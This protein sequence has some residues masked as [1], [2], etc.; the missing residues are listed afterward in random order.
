MISNSNGP[1]LPN[2]APNAI[3]TDVTLYDAAMN[4]FSLINI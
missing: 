1:T 3:K 2:I 4:V